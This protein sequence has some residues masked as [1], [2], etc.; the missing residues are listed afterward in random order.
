MKIKRYKI[1]ENVTKND[2][3]RNC[4]CSWS[5]GTADY[6]VEGAD[7][8]I[9]KFGEFRKTDFEFSIMIAFKPNIQDWND[10]NNILIIDDEWCQPYTPFYDYFDK[11]VY[12]FP[13]LE[14]L[15][16]EYNKFMDSLSFLEEVKE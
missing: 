6:V 2:I 15:I 7:F 14:Y 10:F 13:T 3:I 16:S 8:T 11:E 5:N 4:H 12:D 1:R 9:R